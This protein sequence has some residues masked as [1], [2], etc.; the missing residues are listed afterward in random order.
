MRYGAS[1]DR[2]ALVAFSIIVNLV[3]SYLNVFKRS[4]RS[5]GATLASGHTA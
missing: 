3:Y 1:I 5:L 2:V 4:V